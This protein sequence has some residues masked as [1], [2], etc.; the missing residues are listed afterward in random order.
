MPVVDESQKARAIALHGERAE[1][2]DQ[3]YT[4]LEENPYEST[5]RYG[6]KKI[7]ELID[8]ILESL[9]KNARA[10]DVGCGTGFNVARLRERG[11]SVIGVEPSDDM[12]K[13]AVANNPGADIRDGDIE[14]LSLESGSFDV[15]LCIEVIRYLLDPGPALA[16]LARVLKP[17]GVAIVTAAPRWS[18]NGYA[19]VNL[20]T[21]RV[22]V[23]SF[24]K[25]RQSFM[26]VR[27]AEAAMRSAGFSDVQIHGLF[28]GPW[29]VLG[30]ISPDALGKVLK[31]WEVL[32]D[33]LANR[34][35]LRDLTNHLVLV[36]RK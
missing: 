11:F 21:S 9:P 31:R 35:A 13:R 6:R 4:D 23:P 25:L 33:R 7:E 16:E 24:M 2:F 27:S 29:H 19:A 12:R 32:D 18:L 3:H 26:S 22:Q 36:G 30:R 14:D 5:F 28:L 1:R 8:D 17:G 34:P 20:V 10:L 15:V